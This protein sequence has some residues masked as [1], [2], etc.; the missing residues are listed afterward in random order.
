VAQS[1]SPD[2]E[3]RNGIGT[4]QV[5][6]EASLSVRCYYCMSEE[7]R[8]EVEAPYTKL[9]IIAGSMI[10]RRSVKW[11]QGM[12]KHIMH[13]YKRQEIALSVIRLYKMMRSKPDVWILCDT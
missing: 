2:D 8:I 4:F 9:R 7:H 11:S 6:V 13:C 12:W 5:F 1:L 10:T 3:D